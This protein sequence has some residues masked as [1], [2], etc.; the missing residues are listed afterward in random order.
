MPKVRRKYKGR[1]AVL[2]QVGI[3]KSLS[4]PWKAVTKQAKRVRGVRMRWWGRSGR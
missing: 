2:G 1:N 3:F 4:R